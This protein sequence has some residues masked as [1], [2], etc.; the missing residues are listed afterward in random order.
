MG[1]PF[2]NASESA[3][4]SRSEAASAEKPPKVADDF[5]AK[6]AEQQD[7]FLTEFVEFLATNKKWWLTPIILILLLLGLAALFAG[8][9]AAPFIYTLF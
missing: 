6:A 5:A 2:D 4:T 8:S 3:G 7:S 1:E 9:G